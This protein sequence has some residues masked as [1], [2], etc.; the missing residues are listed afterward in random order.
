MQSPF[1]YARTVFSVYS[2]D[3]QVGRPWCQ[4]LGMDTAH[5]PIRRLL[6]CCQN[7]TAEGKLVNHCSQVVASVHR[8]LVQ[9]CEDVDRG[10]ES[11]ATQ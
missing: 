4:H 2:C 11:W 1:S 6:S 3:I 5:T 10:V 9:K 8:P 7:A